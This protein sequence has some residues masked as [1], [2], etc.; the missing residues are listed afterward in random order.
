[1]RPGLMRMMVAYLHDDSLL[2]ILAVTSEYRS[3]WSSTW[4][5]LSQLAYSREMYLEARAMAALWAERDEET[6]LWMARVQRWRAARDLNY[7][8]TSDTEIDSDSSLDGL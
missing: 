1:M 3:R 2:V 6:R 8:G 5:Y 4:V 7:L